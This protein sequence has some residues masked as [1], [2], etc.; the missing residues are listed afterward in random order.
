MAIVA[1]CQ[2]YRMTALAVGAVAERYD[3]NPQWLDGIRPL[4]LEIGELDNGGEPCALCQ[5]EDH[6]VELQ[7]YGT[8]VEDSEAVER[9]CCRGCV[10]T[11]VRDLDDITIELVRA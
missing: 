7:V 1:E 8:S 6:V 3:L 5:L 11:A 9:E 4:V 10:A 2:T